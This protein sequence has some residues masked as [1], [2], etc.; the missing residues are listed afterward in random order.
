MNALRRQLAYGSFAGLLM[1]FAFAQDCALSQAITP[2]NNDGKQDDTPYVLKMTTREVVVDVV[3]RDRHNHPVND[4]KVDELQ[5]MEVGKHSQKQP[6]SILAFHVIDPAKTN[7]RAEQPSAGFRLTS[8]GGCAVSTT[9]HYELVYPASSESG[10]HEILVTTSRPHVTLSFRRR[11]YVGETAAPAKPQHQGDA[12]ASLR[13]AAC[14]HSV[15]PS[16]ISLIAQFVPAPKKASLRYSLVIQGDSLAFI[17]LTDETRRVQLDYGICTFDEDGAP[18]EY[19]HTSVERVLTQP[20]YE[21]ALVR[22]L[23]NLLDIQG[24]KQPTLTRFV[25]RDRVTGNLGS[26]DVVR[27]LPPVD[28]GAKQKNTKPPSGSIR[29]FGSVVPRP[30]AF[31]GDVFELPASTTDLP[32]FWDMDPI[33]SL[34]VD[35]L[36]V[37]DQAVAVQHREGGQVVMKT[38]GIPGVTSRSAWFGIDYH[39]EFWVTTPG[40]YD[41]KLTSDD[42]ARLYIDDQLVINLDGVHAATDGDGHITLSAGRH[43]IHVPYFQGPPVALAL[44]LQVKAP[45][46]EKFRVFDLRDFRA[47]V[48]TE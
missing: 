5:V 7:E 38:E 11:Y 13:E 45:G 30:G 40:E 28:N 34:Y 46:E 27:P 44:V 9:M 4:L 43:S 22:G 23:P 18:M 25:V 48:G 16:S 1:V 3:A 17:A 20:E 15:L 35:W 26:L 8:G 2:S 31:C 32:D 12:S 47:P 14:Y 29:G 36:A 42:G 19:M 24:A 10:Y 39:G 41:F 37:P 21:Q 6:K 33:G